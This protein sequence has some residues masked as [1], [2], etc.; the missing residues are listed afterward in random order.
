MVDD[1]VGAGDVEGAGVDE[2]F[3]AVAEVGELQVGVAGELES[4][5]EQ[6]DVDFDAGGA[7]KLEVDLGGLVSLGRAGEYPSAAGEEGSGE[8]ADQSLGLIGADG[9][10][11]QAPFLGL[12]VEA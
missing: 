7:G 4:G 10:E 3:G 2:V 12:A 8:E 6:H 9:G 5:S 11:S 1:Q